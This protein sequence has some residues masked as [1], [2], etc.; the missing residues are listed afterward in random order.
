[1]HSSEQLIREIVAV[2]VRGYLA[3]SDS[4]RDLVIAVETLGKHKPFFS[5]VAREVILGDLDTGRQVNE[6]P[7]LVGERLT[8]RE[9]EIVKLLAEGKSSQGVA[10]FLGIS[11]KT[12]VETHRANLM[13]KLD[14]HSLSE[15]VRY[16]H[17]V[18]PYHRSM[19]PIVALGGLGMPW[20]VYEPE[21]NALCSRAQT[22]FLSIVI[23]LFGLKEVCGHV[24]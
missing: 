23:I 10:S 21:S 7:E 5:P 17:C 8:L 3:K 24:R 18:N 9:R 12:A 13:R 22:F 4:D 19:T 15:L 11:V 6:V 2:G 14:L 20:V 16:T 1:M